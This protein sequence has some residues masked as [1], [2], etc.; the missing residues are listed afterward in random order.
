MANAR[1]VLADRLRQARITA[2]YRSQAALARELHVSRPVISKAE[3][4]AQAVPSADV[5]AAIAAATGTSAEEL[6]DLA[7]R[8]RSG[9]PEWFVPY[10]S[11]EAVATAIRCWGPL[12]VPGLLQTE[13]YAR[14]LL[15]IEGYAGERLEEL[16]R[17]RLERQAVIGQAR[18]TVVID[19]S[20]VARCL[21]SAQIMA[22]QCGHLVT[23]AETRQ[24]RVHVVPEGANVGLG[25]GFAIASR[26]GMSTVSLGTIIRDVT[27]T[28]PDMADGAMDAFEIILGA[29]MPADESLDFLRTWEEKWKQQL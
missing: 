4:P 9:T 15:T 24:V 20:V 21:G 10:L 7:E 26:D 5:V 12:A 16:L 3:N 27:S 29:A 17:T 6:A 2:G 25:G 28:A 19:H 14:T 23:L 11:A 18:I 13:D 22:E 1:E 8:T